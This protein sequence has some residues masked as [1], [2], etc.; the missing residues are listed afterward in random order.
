MSNPNKE[1]LTPWQL[2]ILVLSIYILA[3]LFVESVFKLPP[4]VSE[5]LR[6]SDTFICFIFL[7][8]FFMRLHRAESKLGFLKWG[9]LDF[10][11]SIPTLDI[12]R[13]GRLIRV[14]RILRILRAFRSTKLLL[15]FSSHNAPKVH[16]RLPC[17]SPSRSLS[18]LRLPS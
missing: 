2:V 9:W 5:I 4:D 8:D 3:A 13:W 12:F 11:S 6:I 10:V 17:S 15:T 18:F 1:T 14:I 7:G 16:L